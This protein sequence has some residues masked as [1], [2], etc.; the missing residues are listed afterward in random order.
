LSRLLALCIAA[1]IV[2]P[3]TRAADEC[4]VCHSALGD[5]PSTMYPGDIHYRKGIS[6]SGCHGGNPESS[7]PEKAMDTTA[8]FIGVPRGNAISAA[9]GRCHSNAERMKQWTS[10]VPTG[11]LEQ[12]E[13]SVHGKLSVEGADRIA[14]C[15]N[16]H[17]VHQIAAVDN[18]KS[19]VYPTNVVATCA[20]CH[21]NAVY[22]RSYDPSLPVDQLEKYR[23]SIHG[24]RNAKGD[25]KTAE[26]ASCHGSHGILSAKDVKSS[27]YPTN[28]PSTCERCHSDAGYMKEYGIPTDQYA[29][30]AE[31]VHGIALLQKNDLGAPACNGCHGNHGAAPPGVESVS[32]VCGTCHA[33]NADLFSASPHKK[34]FDE[35][36]LPECETCHGNHAIIVATDKL[37][38]VSPEAVCSKCHST[39]DFP[40]GYQVAASMRQLIDS[41][42]TSE[43]IADSL[44]ENAEQK[45]M[46]ISEAKYKLR[47]IRQARLETRTMVH[48][49][50]EEKFVAVVTKGLVVA[51]WVSGEGRSALEEYLFR[52]IGLGVSTLILTILA[53]SLWL[54]IRRMERNQSREKTVT[55][56]PSIT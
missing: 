17:G 47:E 24:I 35:R 23:T 38:G 32:K 25:R 3:A 54:F 45:G 52:R 11:Q 41:L 28:I 12:L 56:N 2:V 50:D 27:V 31:S 51:A 36:H 4:F 55:H 53:V 22:I 40:R 42:E 33:L 44:V 39:T 46:E 8:G 29:S 21:N 18:P 37:L 48:S 14:Q 13:A 30:Y 5:T 43:A 20:R 16:C 49:F 9:C 19:P 7:D 26:C 15:T 10:S 6:C 1:L 34:A